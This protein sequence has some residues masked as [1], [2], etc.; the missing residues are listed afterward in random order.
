M[1]LQPICSTQRDPS[2]VHPSEVEQ[3]G[4]SVIA[5]A[6]HAA[7]IGVGAMVCIARCASHGVRYATPSHPHV[8]VD[9]TVEQSAGTTMHVP[10]ASA[11]LLRWQ[12]NSFGQKRALL[13]VGDQHVPCRLMH[14][15]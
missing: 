8:G 9:R 5:G 12:K 3:P 10:V 7:Q 1:Q 13:Q 2:H 14:E 6:S 4:T 11:Q 15:P